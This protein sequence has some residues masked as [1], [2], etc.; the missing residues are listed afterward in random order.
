MYGHTPMFY[1]PCERDDANS[2]IVLCCHDQY[3]HL[4][5]VREPTYMELSE[6]LHPP[7][8]DRET[9]VTVGLISGSHFVNHMY[10]VLLPPLFGIL[11]TEFDVSL[12]AL[13]FAVGVQGITSTALQLPFG[14]LSDNHGRGMTLITGLTLTAVA[15]FILASALDYGWLLAGQA[16]L[17]AGLA[18]HHPAHFPMLSAATPSEHRGRAFS[19]HGFAGNLGYAAAPALITLV[20]ALNGT[21]WRDALLLVGTIGAGYAVLAAL[22]VWGVLSDEVTAPPADTTDNTEL[23]SIRERVTTELRSLF[24]SPAILALAVLALV[25]S[26]ANWGIRSYA[27]IL[28]TDGYGLELGLAN[29]AYTAMFTLSAIVILVGGELSDRIAATPILIASYL[30]LLVTAGLVGTLAV[31]PLFA[32]VLVLFTGSA[33]SFGAP[34]RSKLTDRLSTQSDLGK[35]FALITVGT[36]LSGAVAPPLFGAIIERVGLTAAFYTIAAL[37]IVSG[38]LVILVVKRFF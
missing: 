20:L 8:V 2:G 15:V 12:T 5:V 6:R 30:G 28:L 9:T 4:T 1:R 35:N 11:A 32:V 3:V 26:M 37:G 27:V 31:S 21:T 34:A 22:V 29:T 38:V 7:S 33:I 10:L 25:T 13:G 14:Y 18:A 16:L 23:P 17:G 19:L 24:T 36:V